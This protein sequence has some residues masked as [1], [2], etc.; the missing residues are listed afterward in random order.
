MSFNIA[1]GFKLSTALPI[2][3]RYVFADQGTRDSLNTLLR[4]EG[5]KVYVIADQLFYSLVGGI[6]DAHWVEDASGGGAA[7]LLPVTVT[8]DYTVTDDDNFILVDASGGNV[9]ITLPAVSSYDKALYIIRIDSSSNAVSITPA[10]GTI[11]GA[12]LDG[13]TSQYDAFI[14]ATDATNWFILGRKQ[15]TN[16]LDVLTV[17]ANT[18]ASVDD[19]VIL[20]NANGGT[21]TIT[22]PDPSLYT[23][24]LRIKKIDGSTNTV[25]IENFGSETIDGA[26]SYT[27]YDQYVSVSLVS[28]GTNWS[29]I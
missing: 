10:S 9:D 6:T 13:L 19:D 3:D 15:K 4:Y 25:I 24:I 22:L 1:D 26:T 12:P 21:R 5:L 16:P 20:V 18:A 7:T 28:D 27:I 11:D 2:D 14:L 29:I 17:S 8:A 23:S